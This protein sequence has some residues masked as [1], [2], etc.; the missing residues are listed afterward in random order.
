M[1]TTKGKY[2]PCSKTDIPETVRFDV[3]GRLQGQMIEVAFGGFGRYEHDEGDLY[4]R[5]TD[6][7]GTGGP[8]NYYRWIETTSCRR[9]GVEV[10]LYESC[11]PRWADHKVGDTIDV[12]GAPYTITEIHDYIQ[13][14]DVHG[15]YV[16]ADAMAAE[17]LKGQQ[18]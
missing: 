11:D 13:T 12:D 15:N 9:A 4:K 17:L 10:R 18:S 8:P 1:T 2:V 5:V 3:P 16:I 6:R 7:G 14:G